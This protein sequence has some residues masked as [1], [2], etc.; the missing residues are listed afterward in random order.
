M[1]TGPAWNNQ[2]LARLANTIK[3]TVIF[4]HV[5][6]ATE[7]TQVCEC[8]CHP[9]QAGRFLFMHNGNIGGYE[10]VR[11][12]LITG[13]GERAFKYAVNKG[14]SDSALCFAL[15]LDQLTDYHLA[16][17][18]A[19]M[20]NKI[21]H[22]IRQLDEA[23]DDAAVDEAS[24]LNFII[25]DGITMLSTRYVRPGVN[26]TGPNQ[27][28]SLYF[29]SGTRYE[30]R[31]KVSGEYSMKHADRRDTLAIVTSEPLTDDTGDW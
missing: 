20:L 21:D 9:F 31:N 6:A 11:K 19:E 10:T 25:T 29:S 12:R 18:P 27:A 22:V 28:A 5:R 3:S 24:M 1:S 30:A 14:S 4:A 17:T 26:T 23:C 15:F 8:S 13:L 2:N 16:L 7:G